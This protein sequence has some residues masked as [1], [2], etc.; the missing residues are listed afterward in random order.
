[1]QKGLQVRSTEGEMWFTQRGG[2]WVDTTFD[3]KYK[4][5][6]QYGIVNI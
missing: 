4:S 6:I 2:M 5:L 1:M 3:A